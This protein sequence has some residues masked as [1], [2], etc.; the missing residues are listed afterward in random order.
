[1]SAQRS[2]ITDSPWLW[3]AMFSAVGL[4]ALLATGGKFGKRQAGIE[5]QAQARAAVGDGLT[6][7]QDG[8]G[9]TT[10]K[11][12]PKYSRPGMTKIRL[13]PLAVTLG[14]I[15]AVSVAML[16]REQLKKPRMNTDEHG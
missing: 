4:M 2:P 9:R 12:V 7:T 14:S 13:K 3:F 1:M 5:R 11:N 8:T 16:V 10:A 15:L 6:V